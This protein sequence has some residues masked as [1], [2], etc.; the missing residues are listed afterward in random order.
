MLQSQT[1][2]AQWTA[3]VI[4][5]T[6]NEAS[7]K[8]MEGAVVTIKRNG[9]V[10][11]TVTS[12]ANGKFQAGLLPD[13]IYMIE[14]SK[15]GFVSKKIQVSTKNVPPDDAKYG[16]DIPMDISLFE[17]MDGLDVSILNQ[18]IGKIAFNPETGY[19]DH[20]AAYTKSIQKEM[21]RLKKELAARLKAEEANRKANQ[22]SYDAAIAAADKA[23]NAE[24][25]AEAKPLY[26]QALSIFPKEDYPDFQLADISDK[27]V[28]L[29]AANK[30]YNSAIEKADKAF[31]DREW[32]KATTSYEF[33]L[34]LKETE[35]YPKDK[36]AEI[37]DIVANEKKVTK[38]YNEAI[39]LGDQYLLNREYD[40]SITE[41]K[42]ATTL[43]SYEQYPKD[44]LKE[45][46]DLL[47]ELA[48]KDKG[49]NDAI[50][51]ADSEF[52]AKN[53][54]K[55]IDS[56]TKALGF[57]PDEA[58]PKGRIDEAKRLVVEMKRIQEEYDGF[59]IAADAAFTNK[60]YKQAKLNYE[61][62]SNLMSDEQYPKDK[63]LEIISIL[64]AADKYKK[65]ILR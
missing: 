41:Y 1:S 19:M 43:K 49:Y 13:A 3:D 39:A 31:S 51:Q 4:G 36:I 27:L 64:E 42:K 16:F 22:K 18:P 65:Q 44:K 46:E 56:Y 40:K 45:I 11:K 29:E 62:A 55:S 37:K 47:A 35:Q 34:S 26:E 17:E 2:V 60:D 54:D 59:I 53:Y 30:K 38:E 21:D 58:Y 57:K 7:K 23:F 61:G 8:R 9:A 52:D 24:K 15:P 6:K 32:S 33:A 63:L 25:W 5:T 28:E 50:A 48:E 20:D 14:V 10:W 12:P